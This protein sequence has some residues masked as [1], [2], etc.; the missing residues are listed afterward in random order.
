VAGHEASDSTE[1]HP[2][3]EVTSESRAAHEQ[4]AHAPPL[5]RTSK[6]PAA[7][8][9]QA[10]LGNHLYEALLRPQEAELPSPTAPKRSL[11]A[12]LRR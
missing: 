8:G 2:G 10:P 3:R 4:V 12:S 1:H 5:N 6:C 9:S 11:G 7:P